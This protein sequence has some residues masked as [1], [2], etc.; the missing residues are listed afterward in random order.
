MLLIMLYNPRK[1]VIYE[2]S[3]SRTKINIS[4][5]LLSILHNDDICLQD[6]LGNNAIYFL[7][8]Y[9]LFAKLFLIKKTI[10]FLE[11]FLDITVSLYVVA[12]SFLWIFTLS[13]S[14]KDWS[15]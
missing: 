9:E 12:S 10:T 11:G 3:H 1:S 5:W 14:F 4:S 7:I 6:I 2:T 8:E 13:D 15:L